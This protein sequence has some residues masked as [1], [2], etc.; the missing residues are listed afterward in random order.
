MTMAPEYDP[1]T[2]VVAD[3][4]ER[5]KDVRVGADRHNEGM[6]AVYFFDAHDDESQM[7]GQFA[8]VEDASRAVRLIVAET[9]LEDL[10]THY[11]AM[12]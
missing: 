3:T 2:H 5:L 8:T 6:F 10:A 7:T 4:I 12:R 9:I 11:G 1:S